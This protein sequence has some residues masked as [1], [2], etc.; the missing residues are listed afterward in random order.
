M[1]T[2]P[3]A[4][5][6][7]IP[8]YQALA[9]RYPH[10]SESIRLRKEL[11]RLDGELKSTKERST[12]LRIHG[13]MKSIVRELRRVGILK[14]LH[15]ESKRET[16]YK[17]RFLL[18]TVRR[19]LASVVRGIR[20]VYSTL[21]EDLEERSRRARLSRASKLPPSLFDLRSLD[22]VDRG[23]ALTEW[24]EKRRMGIRGK[25]LSS[26]TKGSTSVS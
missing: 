17:M 23:S 1:R 15:G 22:P 10:L 19:R 14:R 25:G 11:E 7:E 4:A 3:S 8:E 16:N 6:K 5:V 12:K 26:R 9:A 2:L 21:Q 13:E 18:V 20:I 24:I